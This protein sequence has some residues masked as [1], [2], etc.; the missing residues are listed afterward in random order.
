MF[1]KRQHAGSAT[2]QFL[3]FEVTHNGHMSVNNPCPYT[4]SV[5]FKDPP[6]HLAPH[7]WGIL[8]DV[9]RGKELFPNEVEDW[10]KDALKKYAGQEQE[11]VQEEEEPAPGSASAGQEQEDAQ[12]EEEPAPGSASA[13]PN[14]P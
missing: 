12:E 7:A 9:C 10:K 11:D 3:E 5:M 2:Q 6:R 4:V 1:P 14:I 8:R 13:E